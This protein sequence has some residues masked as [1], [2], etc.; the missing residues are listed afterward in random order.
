MLSRFTRASLCVG[1]AV[2]AGCSDAPT[3]A[4]PD[5]TSAPV[6][7]AA[8][9]C[10]G[11]LTLTAGQVMPGVSGTSICLSGGA[12][13]AEYALIPF[14]GTTLSSATTTLDFTASGTASPS[15]APS[16]IPSVGASFDAIASS[17]S[18]PARYRASHAFE[19]GLRERERVNLRRLIGAARAA[20]QRARSASRA[21]FDAI[22]SNPTIGQ[23]LQLNANADSDCTA[24]IYHG[25]RVVAITK[26]AIVVADT[27]NPA[28]GYSDAEYASLGVTFDTLIDPLDRQAFGDPSD[29]DGNG[30]IVLFFTKAVNDLTPTTSKSYIGGFFHGRDLFPTQ[31]TADFAACATSNVGEMFYVM[32]PDPKRGGPFAKA[33]VASEVLGTLAHEY[34]HLINASRRMYVN[35][36]ATDFEETWLNEGL[37]HIAEELLFY[38]VSGLNPRQDIDASTIRASAA[39]VTAFNDYQADNFGRYGEFLS[40]PSKYSVYSDNDSLAT[41]GATWAFLRDAADRRATSDG[42]TW[43]K[44]VNATTTGMTNLRA[45]FGTGVLNEVRD[46]GT[47]VLTDDLTGVDAAYQQPS[48]NFRS[49]FAVLTSSSIFPVATVS[50]AAGT[51]SITLV[52]GATSYIRFAVASGAAASVQWSTP[53]SSVQFTLVRTK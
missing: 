18:L 11:A 25:A 17:A 1:G 10:T 50:L 29:I 24:P 46:W 20:R 34:Q 40:S 45:V 15:M 7:T 37:S 33:N 53:P 3:A 47:S 16:L 4:T 52:G 2:V 48:W 8:R 43:Y 32:V 30:R 31:E 49:I 38:R 35:T 14:Y 23:V 9:T 39:Y 13:G 27:L 6:T 21:S 19:I 28:G 5:T 42:D 22:P 26:S 51:Q 41:R 12:S 36:A 44:L